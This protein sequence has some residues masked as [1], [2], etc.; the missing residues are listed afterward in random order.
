MVKGEI[1]KV[2]KGSIA[3]EAGIEEKDILLT[4]NGEEVLDIFDYR[5]LSTNEELQ[6]LIRKTDGEEWEIEI[7]KDEDEDLGI[8]FC[9]DL[10]DE[11]KSCTNKCIFCFIDQLPKGMRNT[12]YFK[13]D[14]TRLSF[15]TGNY[16][17]LTN[18]NNEQLDRIIKYKMSPVNIS[19]HTTNGELRRKILNN[20][21]ADKIMD[22]I[23]KLSLNGIMMNCQ[24]VLMRDINDGDELEKSINDLTKLYPK[25]SSIS[26]VPVG[27]TNYRDELYN[28]TPFDKNSAYKVIKQV[29]K[30]QEKLMQKYDSRIVYLSDE[31]YLLAGIKIPKY[32]EYEDFPQIE[33]GVGLIADFSYEFENS[34]KKIKSI[35]DKKNVTI[36]IAT[37]S[38]AFDFISKV[39]KKINDKI[40]NI[41]I[42]VYEIR[43]KFFGENVTVTGL[44]TGR[45]IIDQLSNNDLGD[46]LLISKVML[47]S[48]EDIFLDDISVSDLSKKL[49]S[50]VIVCKNTGNDFLQTILNLAKNN[51]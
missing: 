3:E 32:E 7:E 13:D 42:N 25:V 34:L 50:K 27:I 2:R 29:E 18:I 30:W 15:L 19:V 16:V 49:G 20:K 6:I 14:D 26:I 48:G 24:I 31:F 28:L 17:T 10:I 9:E 1:A 39:S 5:Y 33:N 8:E 44:L 51:L 4:I 46:A 12:L 38:L 41:K 43:N 22:M 11:A 35:N 36:S 37:G 21:F 23:E 45:D 47:K 40:P